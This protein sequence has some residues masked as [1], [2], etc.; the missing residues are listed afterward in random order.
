MATSVLC[1]VRVWC[2][3][4][5]FDGRGVVAND[6]IRLVDDIAELRERWCLPHCATSVPWRVTVM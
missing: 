6:A 4:L 2:G 3:A 1:A 5:S